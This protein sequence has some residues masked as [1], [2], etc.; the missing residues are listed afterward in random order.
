MDNI[1]EQAVDA[2]G[3]VAG[4]IEPDPEMNTVD[5]LGD[6]AG[7]DMMPEGKELNIK[8]ELEQRDR[9]RP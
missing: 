5:E 4:N 6:R 7:L 3:A 8:E 9:E 1:Q 2:N